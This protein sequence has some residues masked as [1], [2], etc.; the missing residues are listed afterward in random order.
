MNEGW[1]CDESPRPDKGGDEVPQIG[2]I[3]ITRVYPENIVRAIEPTVRHVTDAVTVDARRLC[4]IDQGDLE[5]SIRPEHLGLKGRIWVGTDH[6][7][8]TEYGSPPHPI[9][10]RHK[11][12]LYNHETDTFF[13]REVRHPGTPAQPFMRPALYRKRVLP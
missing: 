7:H 10:I 1:K 4:P 9:R 8:P 12:V 2:K 11:K 13:G 3:V 6:W 5:R